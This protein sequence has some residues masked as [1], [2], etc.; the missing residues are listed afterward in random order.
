M[1]PLTAAVVTLALLAA[2][3]ALLVPMSAAPT[4][5][6]QSPEEAVGQVG[7]PIPSGPAPGP[8][9]NSVAVVPASPTLISNCIPFGNNVNFDFTGFI[10]R[11]VP[12]F[13]MLTGD[14]FSFDM[15]ALNSTDIRRNIYF[16]TANINPGPAVIA[17][18][19]NVVSQGVAAT[20]WTKVASDTQIPLSPKGNGVSGDYELTY[21]AEAPFAFSGGGLIVGFGGS[22]PGAYADSGCEQVLVTTTS[23]DSSG[24]FYSRFFSKPDQTLGVLDDIVLFLGA[25]G[26][27]LGGI[28]IHDSGPQ[29]VGGIVELSVGSGGSQAEHQSARGHER[30][31]AALAVA[32]AAVGVASV[33]WLRY[34]R[35]V[36]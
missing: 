31:V 5:S 9:P 24:Q 10:Y 35:R 6:G 18:G 4:V 21:T 11:N 33:S 36:G 32:L 27:F 13:G 12:A 1:T 20:S 17:A 16:A 2:L 3:L 25:S 34:R 23:S 22:P 8:P 7:E 26:S 29:P 19:G 14:T 28:I 30:H 15:G